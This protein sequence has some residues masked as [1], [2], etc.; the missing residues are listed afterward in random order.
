MLAGKINIQKSNL[1]NPNTHATFSPTGHNV[2]IDIVPSY[3][4]G[5]LSTDDLANYLEETLAP[6]VNAGWSIKVLIE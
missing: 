5:I 6:L 2:A 1:E 3:P 4:D